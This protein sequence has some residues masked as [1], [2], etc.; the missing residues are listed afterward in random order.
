MKHFITLIDSHVHIYNCFKIK[1]V[2]ESGLNNFKAQC[3]VIGF[4]NLLEFYF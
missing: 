1:K 4:Q 3:E 2:L